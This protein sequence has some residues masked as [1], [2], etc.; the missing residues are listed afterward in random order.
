MWLPWTRSGGQR[1]VSVL[2]VM[3][4]TEPTCC[5]MLPSSDAERVRVTLSSGRDAGMTTKTAM[6][7]ISGTSVPPPSW[8]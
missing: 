7:S 3:L 5:Q 8:T 1:V 2:G 4:V 6:R